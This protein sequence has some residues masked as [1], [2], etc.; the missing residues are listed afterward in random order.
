M[1]GDQR[2][3]WHGHARRGRVRHGQWTIIPTTNAAPTGQSTVYNIG[4]TLSYVLNGV[5]V[6]IPLFAVPITVLPEP[7]LYLDYFLQHDVYS[8]DPFTNVVEPPVP[9]ALGLRVRNLGARIGQQF[10]HHLRPAD[11]HQQRQRSFD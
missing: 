11:H 1:S 10:H 4:G 7:H 8:Q 6:T 3:G 2:G 5:P 9:F